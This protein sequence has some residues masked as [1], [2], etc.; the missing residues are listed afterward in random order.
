MVS[1]STHCPARDPAVL[2]GVQGPR[3]LHAVTC[4]WPHRLLPRSAP[5]ELVPL[6]TQAQGSVS[7]GVFESFRR[8]PRRG[9]PD[10]TAFLLLVS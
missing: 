2:C 10:Q 5:E 1:G 7:R 6:Q 4:G 3:F 8:M 9:W